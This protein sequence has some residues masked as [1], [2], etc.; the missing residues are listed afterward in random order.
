MKIRIL[1]WNKFHPRK[2]ISRPSW[3]ALS[4]SLV[5]DPD[6]YSFSDAEFKAWIYILSIASQKQTDTIVVNYE[7]A[8]RASGIKTA[9]FDS[10]LKK[11]EQLGIV[12]LDV[13]PTSRGRNV[14]VTPTSRYITEQDNTEQDNTEQTT[15]S[16]EVRNLTSS[17]CLPELR[18]D[19]FCEKFLGSAKHDTQKAWL[20]LYQDLD[21]M[22]RE[23][24]K[25]REWLSR[26]QK[27]EPKSSIGVSRFVASWL[28]RG[29]EEH[30][31]TIQ[32]ND[33]RKESFEEYMA[34]REKELNGFQ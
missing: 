17:G 21:F 5:T 9:S 22:R 13:T 8:N 12:A 28:S 16:A 14:D 27:R 26:N 19:D 2:D 24:L 23:F 11:L 6:F 34:R 3:F 1:N 20:E 29:W 30:R 18:F 7:H 33:K 25:M 31:K 4:N 32:T 15:F 10:A